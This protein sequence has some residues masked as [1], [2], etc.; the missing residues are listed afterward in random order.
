LKVP[1]PFLLAIL[2]GWGV[3]DSLQGNAI[4]V[5]NT[6]VMDGLLEEYPHTTLY[7]SGEAV[8]LPPGQMGDSEVGHLNIG[9]GR[10]VPQD[11][12]RINHSVKDG[13]FYHNEALLGAMKHAGESGSTLHLMGLLSDGGVH[14]HIEHLFALLGMAKKE[15]LSK[16]FIH[17]FLD[18]RDVPPRCSMK[19]VRMLEDCSDDA[20]V[21]TMR[22][23]MGRYYA[24]DRDNRWERTKLAY[25]AIVRA[26][27]PRVDSAEEAIQ[28]SYHDGV[29]D[30]FLVP[31]VIGPSAPMDDTD[32]V[33]FFNFRPDR[34][35]QLTRAIIEEDFSEFDRGPAPP[36]PYLVTMT[37]YEDDFG[38]PVAFAPDEVREVLADVIA[39]SGK[40][41]LHI[42]ETEKYAHVTYFFNGGVEELK[43]GE[44]R[45]LIPSPK[46]AT[47]D[48]KPEM[49]AHEVASETVRRIESGKYDFIVLN[50]ANCDMVGHTGIMKAAVKAVEAVDRGLGT[51][52]DA[53]FYSGGSA[54]VTG[55]HGNAETMLEDGYACTAHSCSS[56]PFV[57]A[58]EDKRPLRPGGTLGD[59]APTILEELQLPKPVEMT[60]TS[61]FLPVEISGK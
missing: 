26:E 49:S 6:P 59:I 52:L 31:R 20:G 8:G 34:P 47:Y 51:V 1:R 27:G 9:A 38:V 55:D 4:A 15:G 18:G 35:R 57:N 50:F 58:T 13:E 33:I 30:E 46:V 39:E 32:A 42:A 24:M 44:D 53:I 61:L 48:L 21:G 3:S 19:Y 2:D 14:S 54:F 41:Q 29:G 40:T 56:V 36:L 25:D 16:V 37:E 7:A 23:I 45:V 28:Q 10:L 17:A 11:F 12:Q 43:K 60:G 22:T 5:A